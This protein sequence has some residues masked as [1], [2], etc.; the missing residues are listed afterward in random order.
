[1]FFPSMKP[2]KR[3]KSRNVKIGDNMLLY[4]KPQKRVKRFEIVI[5]DEIQRYRNLKRGLKV[6]MGFYVF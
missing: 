6:D 1:M 3:V 5:F 4:G 2:Q